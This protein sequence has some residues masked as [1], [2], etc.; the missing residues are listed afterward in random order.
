[1]KVDKIVPVS[2]KTSIGEIQVDCNISLEDLGKEFKAS[3]CIGDEIQ[4]QHIFRKKD[5]DKL[6]TGINSN[7]FKGM[8]GFDTEYILSIIQSLEEELELVKEKQ[9]HQITEAY[10][11]A[12]IEILKQGKDFYHYC[13]DNNILPSNYIMKASRWKVASE[14]I[15]ILRIILAILSTM[16]GEPVN[17][18]SVAS[19][20]SGKS[21]I[22]NVAFD[23]V[24][25]HNY[26]IMNYSTP[27][28]FKNACIDNPYLFKNK[29]VR[30]GDRGSAIAEEVMFEVN[31]IIKILNSEGYYHSSKMI[32]QN[33]IIDIELIGK[34]AM[35]FSKVENELSLDSQDVSRG[36]LW[37]P[38]L[39]ND[40]EFKDFY[41]WLDFK[42]NEDFEYEDKLFSNIRNY[43]DWLVTLDIEII[44]PY[45]DALDWLFKGNE[46][47]RRLLN[48]Q[49]NILK[50]LALINLPNKE[51]IDGNRIYVTN[52]D[53][54]MYYKLFYK[55]LMALKEF[56]VKESDINLYHSLKLRY[57]SIDEED[58]YNKFTELLDENH[59]DF[60]DEHFQHNDLFFTVNEVINNMSNV[61]S[62]YNIIGNIENGKNQR[63][64]IRS[65]LKRLENFIGELYI[66]DENW[67]YNGVKPTL[68]YIKNSN[69]TSKKVEYFIKSSTFDIIY[70]YYGENDIKYIINDM[71]KHCKAFK[72]RSNRLVGCIEDI[73]DKSIF[74]CPIINNPEYME[75]EK[76][77]LDKYI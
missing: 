72:K 52:Q 61:R 68:Y 53:F 17:I 22:E 29:I 26:V 59:S 42:T 38:S 75:L 73:N 5:I 43:L 46:A 49:D 23:M 63:N 2:M 7:L 21:I 40:N 67:K 56:K 69:V 47:Y 32:S 65:T 35:C 50:M 66:P 62:V 45:K 11:K 39:D 51:I 57:D 28:S 16:R 19:A 10:E 8:K 27:A 60:Y 55:S 36:I 12:Q 13:I 70:R 30:F 24:H 58:I 74:N 14:E 34:C 6:P 31:S 76:I 44:N 48:K 77:N 20:G 4:N 54:E 64:K 9:Q 33:D 18:I 41:R 15:N 1:M 71:K 37:T 25:E 3:V